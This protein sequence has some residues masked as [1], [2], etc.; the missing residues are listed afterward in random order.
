ML[1]RHLAAKNHA[2]V[3][4][5][6]KTPV[7]LPKTPPRLS[8]SL[9]DNSVSLQELSRRWF[10]RAQAL[11]SA[12]EPPQAA[13][14][15]TSSLKVTNV[16]HSECLAFWPP[17]HVRLRRSRAG[18]LAASEP[19][20]E[21]V[22]QEIPHIV[23]QEQAEMANVSQSGWSRETVLNVSHSGVLQSRRGSARRWPG[24]QAR[25]FL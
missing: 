2:R 17:R 19:P 13:G 22:L 12:L 23:S 9:Q 1:K 21:E 16:S 18:A 20:E 5:P 4:A 15:R 11:S 6:P 8:K 7:R 24:A 10:L 25:R 3:P 14:W